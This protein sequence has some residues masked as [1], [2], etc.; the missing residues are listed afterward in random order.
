[1]YIDYTD[2]L[3]L[4]CDVRE[5]EK[6]Y[7]LAAFNILAH[8]RGDHARNF[9]FPMCDGGEW[10]LS[11]AYDLTFAAGPGG[12]HSTMVAGEGRHLSNDHLVKLGKH[13]NLPEL[14]I[15][16]ILDQIRSAL[17]Q[18]SS[19]APQWGLKPEMTRMI[20]QKLGSFEQ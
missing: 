17:S 7:R 19:L 2:L 16:E 18:W 9:S 8:N 12:E 10:K 3:D 14:R 15:S 11:S 5:V 1:M 6:M 13:A 4:T 20:S